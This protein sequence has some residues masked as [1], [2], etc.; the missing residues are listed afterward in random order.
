MN[1]FSMYDR[2][3]TDLRQMLSRFVAVNAK[4]TSMISSD[5]YC[6]SCLLFARIF[7]AIFNRTF[8]GK[9]KNNLCRHFD[10]LFGEIVDI[11]HHQYIRYHH[12]KLRFSHHKDQ[13]NDSQAIRL[14]HNLVQIFPHQKISITMNEITSNALFCRV[15]IYCLTCEI[16]VTSH[17]HQSKIKRSPKI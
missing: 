6:L 14:N 8:N 16:K 15:F 5:L 13:H 12:D 1:G 9:H 10:A 11:S 2:E 3:L 7:S 17:H 4:F